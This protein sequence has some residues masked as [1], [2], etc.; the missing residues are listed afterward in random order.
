MDTSTSKGSYNFAATAT[1]QNTIDANP[2]TLP[3]SNSPYNLVGGG[4]TRP[5]TN[6]PGY[7]QITHKT[8]TSFAEPNITHSSSGGTGAGVPRTAASSL[9]V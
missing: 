6:V 5:V 4:V 8:M 2:S 3:S 9:E 7:A 1:D